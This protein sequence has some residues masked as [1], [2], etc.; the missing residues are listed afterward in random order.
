MKESPEKRVLIVS[1]TGLSPDTSNGRTMAVLLKSFERDSLAQ[2]YLHGKP[3]ETACAHSFCV[4]DRDAMNAFLFR[5]KKAMSQTA[6]QQGS[7]NNE[8]GASSDRTVVQTMQKTSAM[9]SSQQEKAPLNTKTVIHRSCKNLVLRDIVWRSNRWWKKDFSEFLREFS[10]EVVLLQAGDSPFMYAI[11]R[12]IAK[13]FHASLVMFNTENYVLKKRLYAGAKEKSIWHLLLRHRLRVQYRR[14]MKKADF[15]IYNTQWLEEAYQKAYPHSG[16]SRTFY[17]ATQLQPAKSEPSDGFRVTY[18]GN[19]G[20]G[21]TVPLHE[22]ARVLQKAIPEATLDIYGKFQ[23]ARERS[24]F[25][26]LPNVRYFGIVPYEQVPAILATSTLVL[27]CENPKRAENLR[28]AFSTKIADSLA[29]GRPFLV[30]SSREYP[31]VNYLAE[32]KCAH[33]A[34]SPEELYHILTACKDRAFCDSTLDNAHKLANENHSVRTNAE[35]MHQILCS[36]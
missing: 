17:V 35:E 15:C 29:C 7:A 4:S 27:H 5:K 14:F 20:V 9:Q 30:Y 33:I 25:E 24:A 1:N 13:R 3:D 10:P 26:T 34:S 16:K 18:C 22:F 2:F 8:N 28:Y 11:A 19:L 36:L 6:A 21:R 32:H 23:T 12:K 31:F